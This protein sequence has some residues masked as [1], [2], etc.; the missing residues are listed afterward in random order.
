MNKRK[1]RLFSFFTF[2]FIPWLG[3]GRYYIS[4]FTILMVFI[5]AL[6]TYIKILENL[7]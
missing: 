6:F 7:N 3:G 4:E 2:I 1:V 5:F